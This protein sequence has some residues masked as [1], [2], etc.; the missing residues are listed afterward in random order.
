MKI[1]EAN[2]NDATIIR[3]IA[4]IV[5]PVAYIDILSKEQLAY[6][7]QNFYGFEALKEQMLTRTSVF[8][9]QGSR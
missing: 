2:I 5:W 8:Y 9:S 3:Q 7:L 6:M 1:V 4:E